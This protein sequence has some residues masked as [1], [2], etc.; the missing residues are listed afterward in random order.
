M[1]FSIYNL[2]V[3]HL[4]N[5]LQLNKIQYSNTAASTELNQHLSDTRKIQPDNLSAGLFILYNNISVC[6][7]AQS[8]DLSLQAID[9]LFASSIQD[10]WLLSDV[11]CKA[12]G[13]GGDDEG[14]EDD[15][16]FFRS[17]LSSGGLSGT[18]AGLDSE[19]EKKSVLCCCTLRY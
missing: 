16:T 11:D 6:F 18:F 7:S 12:D 14:D 2:S 17:H 8:M 15:G 4:Y 1:N 5:T 10:G 3:S 9:F 13:I 19:R